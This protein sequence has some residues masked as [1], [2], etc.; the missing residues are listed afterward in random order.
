M[1]KEL[2]QYFTINDNLQQYV[3]EM[4]KNRGHKLLEP[5]FGAGHLL[6]KFKELDENYPMVLFEIDTTINPCVNLN[7]FQNV[8]Y[9]NFIQFNTDEK[10]KTIIGNPP[11]VKTGGTNL[12][13]Q[14]IEK[15]FNMLDYGGEI[16]FIVPSD[17]IK[18]TSA[19]PIIKTMS[20][21]GTFTNFLFPNDEKLFDNASIDVVVFRY[22]KDIIEKY[23]DVNGEKK[24]CNITNGIITFGDSIINGELLSNVFDVYVGLVSGKDD[25]YKVPFGNIDIL[26]DEN[27]TQKF[28]FIKEF[29]GS[30]TEINNY[31]LT[32]KQK[33]L[34]RRI[35]KFNEN[36]WFEWGAPRNIKT[37]E[38]NLGRPCI[39]IRNITRQK[40]VAFKGNVTHFGGKLLCLIPKIEIDLDDV[41]EY[42]NS[43]NFKQNYMYAERF[44][45]GHR[46]LSNAMIGIKLTH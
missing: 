31:L 1:T 32:N 20:K 26:T 25:I 11:Y 39:Y 46:Q 36:N 13:I 37:I 4:V 12:Y 33:L 19:S 34:E 42:L 45:I 28:I 23:T 40:R 43:D 8:T 41:V 15:C 7:C 6:K 18:L 10:F 27:D 44:K 30:D 5:S 16:I 14:F 2:G 24:F 3:F 38:K 35:K 9:C 22:E 17:F 21:S 29:P